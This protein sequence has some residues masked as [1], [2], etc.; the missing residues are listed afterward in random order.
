M[1]IAT[2]GMTPENVDEIDYIPTGV[3]EIRKKSGKTNSTRISA[4]PTAP[5]IGVVRA[6]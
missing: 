6:D 4:D 3:I 1:K 2:V 5:S